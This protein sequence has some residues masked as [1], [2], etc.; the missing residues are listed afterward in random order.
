MAKSEREEALV[1]LDDASKQ[2]HQD[3]LDHN[4]AMRSL[5]DSKDQAIETASHE[6]TFLKDQLTE[7]EAQL[8]GVRKQLCDK[9]N[10]LEAMQAQ[11]RKREQ[12][13]SNLRQNLQYRGGGLTCRS[14]Q[15]KQSLFVTRIEDVM[16]M[17]ASS[18]E[19]LFL[20]RSICHTRTLTES[21]S[22]AS[23]SCL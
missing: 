8:D 13:L 15:R 19:G 1:A 18:F 5:S 23:L 21:S 11:A 20:K 7:K 3:H 17:R 4:E 10:S 2:I 22:T 16:S 6:T 9:E 14:C 12:I